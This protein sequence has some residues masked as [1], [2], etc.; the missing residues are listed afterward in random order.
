MPSISGPVGSGGESS[1]CIIDEEFDD[2]PPLLVLV[3]FKFTLLVL[4]KGKLGVNVLLVAFVL[5]VVVRVSS[6]SISSEG[7]IDVVLAVLLPSEE[8]K[9]VL[10]V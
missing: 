4:A 3:L 6:I 1:V 10:E 7:T 5:C 9:L 8:E 2:D